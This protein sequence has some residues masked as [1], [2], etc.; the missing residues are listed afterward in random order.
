M[1]KHEVLV[2]F[3]ALQKSCEKHNSW[4]LTKTLHVMEKAPGFY[5]TEGVRKIGFAPLDILGLPISEAHAVFSHM[6]L[7]PTLAI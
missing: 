6:K 2:T 3:E 4:V 1:Q 5:M 7:T